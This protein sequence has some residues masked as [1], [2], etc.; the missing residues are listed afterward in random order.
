MNIIVASR[1][2][3]YW[4]EVSF[5]D[6]FPS[7]GEGASAISRVHELR[8]LAVL[9]DCNLVADREILHERPSNRSWAG[10]GSYDPFPRFD[11]RAVAEE[12]F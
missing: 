5:R 8:S 1:L 2:P 6:E 9:N 3:N 7:E 10:I 4:R 12:M 11:R